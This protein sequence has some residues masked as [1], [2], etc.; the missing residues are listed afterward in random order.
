MKQI[1]SSQV[2]SEKK[3]SG[4]CKVCRHYNYCTIRRY[5]Y[6]SYCE[7]FDFKEKKEEPEKSKDLPK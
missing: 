5:G 3:E 2:L 6:V 7:Y 4:I 1:E